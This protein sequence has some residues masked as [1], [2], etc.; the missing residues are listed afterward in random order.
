MPNPVKEI[1]FKSLQDT[2]SNNIVMHTIDNE[3]GV[4]E[5]DYEK[6]TKAILKSLNS[7]GY[8]IIKMKSNKES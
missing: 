6:I 8:K 3:H 5:I 7:E 2:A 1:I 4:I